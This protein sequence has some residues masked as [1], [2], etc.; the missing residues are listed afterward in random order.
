MNSK[1]KAE[2]LITAYK[3]AEF[4]ADELIGYLDKINCV[5]E[6]TEEKLPTL[7]MELQ[8]RES[9][10]TQNYLAYATIAGGGVATAV[11]TTLACGA[12]TSGTATYGVSA[13]TLALASTYGAYVGIGAVIPVLGWLVIPA[14]SIPMLLRII[15]D[16]KVK[17]YLRDNKEKLQEKQKKISAYREKMHLFIDEIQKRLQDV[18]Q[19][20]KEE[21]SN[22]IGEYQESAKKLAKE[23]AI[24]LDDL[25]NVDTN[26]RIQKYNEIILNQYRLQKE[27]EDKLDYLYSEYDKLL[28]EKAELERKIGI[29]MQ[30]LN[31]M[32]CPESV[33]NQALSK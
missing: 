26:G 10:K 11:G 23:V 30:L 25:I 21:L 3:R 7:I 19:K 14:V 2:V 17:K 24:Q 8:N 22:K 15:N 6:I 1:N 33:I 4:D 16:G 28:K 13:T 29:L 9:K 18:E 20:L 31:T 5:D 32:G 27:L 12:L